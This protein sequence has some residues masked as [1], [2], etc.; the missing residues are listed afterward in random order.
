MNKA[1]KS[2]GLAFLAVVLFIVLVTPMRDRI[3]NLVFKD[4]AG[5]FQETQVIGLVA[6]YNP[7]VAEI[8][9]ILQKANVYSGPVDGLMGAETR[10]AIEAFQKN[11]GLKPT[12]RIDAKTW[13]VLSREKEGV[14]LFLHA[15]LSPNFQEKGVVVEDNQSQKP[16]AQTEVTMPKTESLNK[17]EQIQTALKESGF[18]KGKIDGKF[19][20]KTRKAVKDF[21]RF[22]GLKIDGK[23]G[24]KTWGE[25]KQYLKE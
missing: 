4:R 13:S 19:G 10:I 12:G 21:Q 17:V 16:K 1:F 24:A 15:N 2:I 6:M 25:L 8:Q 5:E 20:R 18:Y 9:E 3:N 14:K 7:R 23:V 11:K 22:K